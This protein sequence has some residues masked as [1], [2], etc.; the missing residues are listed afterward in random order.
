MKSIEFPLNEVQIS[1]LKLTE[2]L[3]DDELQDLKRLII[4]FKARRLAMLADQVWDEKGWT[5]E[6]MEQFLNMH[7]RTPYKKVKQP[8]PNA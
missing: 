6:T 2:N 5:E 4:A 1:L 8:E 7:M 3:K